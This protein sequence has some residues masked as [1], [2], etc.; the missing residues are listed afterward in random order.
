MDVLKITE[1]LIRF[2]SVS[3]E[4]AE[5]EKCI[6]YCKDYFASFKNV[7]IKFSFKDVGIRL[8]FMDVKYNLVF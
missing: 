7:V 1:D 6:T 8:S 5:L 4:I 2:P 3:T